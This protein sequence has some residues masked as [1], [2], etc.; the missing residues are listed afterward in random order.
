MYLEETVVGCPCYNHEDVSCIKRDHDSFTYSCRYFHPA[1][2]L[3]L[4]CE[5]CFLSDDFFFLVVLGTNVI[6]PEFL[7][8]RSLEPENG[9]HAHRLLQN[10]DLELVSS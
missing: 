6:A 7:T 2:I 5:C 9:I 4:S 1:A 8:P 10:G 3:I